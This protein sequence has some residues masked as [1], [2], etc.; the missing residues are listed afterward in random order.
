M[1]PF[2][3]YQPKTKTGCPLQETSGSTKDFPKNGAKHEDSI[4]TMQF[5]QQKISQRAGPILYTSLTNVRD[6]QFMLVCD[7]A[8]SGVR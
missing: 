7:F 5:M 4:N 1:I 6:L 8:S 2:K 3:N